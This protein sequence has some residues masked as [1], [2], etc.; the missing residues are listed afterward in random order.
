MKFKIT[1]MNKLVCNAIALLISAFAT[2]QSGNLTNFQKM[3]DFLP[4]APNAAAIIKHSE[5]TLNK[6][7]GAPS[8]SIPLF[9][10]KGNKLSAGVSLGYSSTG[11]KVDEIASRAGCDGDGL[12]WLRDARQ[13]LMIL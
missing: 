6:N 7:T 13:H 10:V 8:I 1:S 2:A 5:I 3:V 4:P 11:I 9:T 12:V